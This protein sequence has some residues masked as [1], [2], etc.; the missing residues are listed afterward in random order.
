MYNMNIQPIDKEI[1]EEA[2]RAVEHEAGL[3]LELEERVVDGVGKRQVDAVLHLPK[4]RTRLCVEIKRWVQNANLGAII[5]Q[6]RALPE[7]G[8]LVAD[9]V[10]PNMAQ[11]LRAEG[12]QFIDAQGNAYINIEKVYV[13]VT[14][15]RPDKPFL[16]TQGGSN[17]AFEPMGLKV[18]YAFLVDPER[19]NAPYREIAAMAGVALGT[20]GWVINGL[21]AGGYLIDRGKG[22][23]RRLTHY[24]RLLD[25]WVETYPERLQPKLLVGEFVAENPDWWEALDLK[26]RHAYWGGEVAAKKYTDYLKPKAVTLYAGEGE[27]R[28]ILPEARLRNADDRP[29]DV[30]GAVR[31]YRPFWPDTGKGDIYTHPVLTYADLVATGDARNLETARMIYDRYIDQR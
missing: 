23:K 22:S 24:R 31:I 25:R 16:P 3:R 13:F 26:G 2:L 11:R 19:V 27:E 29:T 10:N 12:V 7:K 5:N 28:W 30:A 1:L 4:T 15:L 9:Y 14:G 6:I 8:V 18:I 17:R 20:V 21:K